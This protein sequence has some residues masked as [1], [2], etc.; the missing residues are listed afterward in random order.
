MDSFAFSQLRSFFSR[1]ELL[2][3]LLVLG[4]AAS[5]RAQVQYSIGNP[6]NEAQY[7]LELINRARANGGAEATRLGLSGLQEGP[8]SING[9]AW[10]IANSVQP[11]SWSVQLFNAAQ[12][13][14]TNLNNNDQ[15]FLGGSP[16][17]FGGTTPQ[18]RIAAA[19]YSAAPYSGPT[20]SGGFFP[21]PENIAEAVSQGSGP[22][23]GAKLIAEVLNSH[24]NLFTDQTVPGRGHR[25]TTMLAFWR[26]AG[27]GIA[28]GTDL[29]AGQTWDSL[30]IVQDFSAQSGGTPFI[31]GVVYQDTNGNGFYDPGEGIGG[32]RVDVTGS[33]FFAISSS[34]GGY[35]VPVPGNGSYPVMFSGGGLSTTQTTAVVAGGLNAKLDRLAGGG[36]GTLANLV[37]ISTRLNV[38]P[39]DNR[40]IGGFIV[41]GT[42]AKKV[43][44]RALGPS[45]SSNGV[46][47]PGR[48]ANTTLQLVGPG[49]VIAT[50]DNWR[51]GGQ[52]TQIIASTV[53][54]PNDLESAIVATLPANTTAY[55][56]IVEGVGNTSGVGSVEVYDLDQAA[57]S[58]LA[59]IST[60]GLVQ[61]GDN[62]M[63][64]GFI[65]SGTGSRRVIVRAIGPSLNV[66]GVPL[67]GRL[68]DTT[69][70]IKNQN[71]MTLFFNDDWHDTQAAEIIATGVPPSDNLESAIV[72]T[73]PAAAYTAIVRGFNSATGVALVEAFRLP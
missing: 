37:N 16:H 6:S 22:F 36:G 42:Q 35:S 31:T 66:N 59:N 53:P 34:S 12:A 60:R 30:Y 40:L 8:P 45:L 52:E 13:H 1:R 68:P 28:A 58:Q 62:V 19:G 25:N 57:D 63:I 14:A 3:L 44:V 26:E 51:T 15:F 67:A 61:T 4:L 21:G 65:I 2:V 69:L 33:G 38:Q 24:N 55:S 43:I 64:G 39:G 23:T 5:A 20:T 49:G 46:P 11:L 9:Q 17:T 54:P 29:N 41:T 32:V 7:M 71:G 48:L 47:V 27:I 10:T 73:L 70:E 50:N 72:A 56:V 18:Q